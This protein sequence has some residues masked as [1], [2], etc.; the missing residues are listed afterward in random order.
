MR[1]DPILA[2]DWGVFQ[3]GTTQE[4][5]HKACEEHQMLVAD[6][7]RKVAAQKRITLM[8]ED[9]AYHER[10]YPCERSSFCRGSHDVSVRFRRSSHTMRRRHHVVGR[11]KF[12]YEHH[13]P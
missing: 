11:T 6:E 10:R 1:S 4:E 9:K 5:Y 2:A 8:N 7:A 3:L 12:G 13:T